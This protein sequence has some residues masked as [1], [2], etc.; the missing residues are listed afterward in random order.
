[1][2]LPSSIQALTDAT[3]HEQQE[4]WSYLLHRDD[5]KNR[6]EDFTSAFVYIRN[7]A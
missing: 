7:T 6:V 1:M 4:N 5:R 2:Q 3:E